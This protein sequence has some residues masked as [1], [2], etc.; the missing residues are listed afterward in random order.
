MAF[1][2][3]LGAFSLIVTNFQS[4]SSF[5]AVIARLGSLEEAI[6]RGDSCPIPRS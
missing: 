1:T 4:I 2:H 5:T 3:L 6:D